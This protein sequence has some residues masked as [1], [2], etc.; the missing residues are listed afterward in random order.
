L[1]IASITDV[2]VDRAAL[3]DIENEPLRTFANAACDFAHD[4]VHKTKGTP[5]ELNSDQ[6][7][8]FMTKEMVTSELSHCDDI[9]KKSGVLMEKFGSLVGKR[10]LVT[11]WG[12]AQSTMLVFPPFE[13]TGKTA[14]DM[15][16][17]FRDHLEPEATTT[18][19]EKGTQYSFTARHDS[20]ISWQLDE[21]K[22]MNAMAPYIYGFTAVLVST[23]VG[24]IFK[25]AFLPIKLALTVVFPLC[26][27]YGFAVYVF[28]QNGFEHIGLNNYANGNGLMYGC[29]FLTVGVLFGL[30]IDYDIFFYARVF[31]YRKTGYDNT[32]AV[33]LA[34][35]DTG[36]VISVAG[37]LLAMAFFFV[38]LSSIPVIRMLGFV[39]FFGTCMDTF[40]V[41]SIVA[42]AFL[43]YFE[44]LNYWPTVMPKAYKSVNIDG[45]TD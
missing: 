5:Y 10:A 12:G 34:L 11:P 15:S 8:F 3:L 24:I 18:F 7:A 43:C 41:R 13:P 23:L 32:S 1:G 9:G 39:Y 22:D 2:D 20:I 19:E 29:M 4:I 36:P 17:Y 33:R 35:V 21:F 27:T 37:L 25:A 28:Q 14:F 38:M 40:V 6:I 44:D 26:A 42:P 30:A 31:E 45:S 16:R